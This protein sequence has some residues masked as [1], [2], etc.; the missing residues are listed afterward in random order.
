MD[1]IIVVLYKQK[2]FES[3]TLSSLSDLSINFCNKLLY[4]WDNS[5]DPLSDGEITFL[6]N[7]FENLKYFN[8]TDNKS[9]SA[10]Y[11]NIIKEVDFDKVFIFD[12][13]STLDEEYFI[14]MDSETI[15]YENIGLFIPYVKSKKRIVSPLFYKV[16]N[17]DHSENMKIGKTIAKNRT[18]FASG[19]CIKE[20]VFKRN[21][22]W[23]D[24]NLAFYGIDYKF[25]LDY[26]DSN[27]NM[28]VINYELAHSLSFNEDE[29]KEVKIKRFTSNIYARFYLAC[30]KFNFFEKVIV[31][32]R[33]LF[34]SFLLSYKYKD[35]NFFLIYCKSLIVFL[36]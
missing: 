24:E 9:L 12:Q 21:N 15:N 29:S 4:V 7:R 17:F 5:P 14:L 23:F 3:K 30:N 13:D 26:G 25:V 33:S 2:V 27:L 1:L 16:I 22:N 8:S 28:Y 31:I 32:I 19:M 10:V 11:N 35:Y 18:A 36:K 6:H 34:E 20:W